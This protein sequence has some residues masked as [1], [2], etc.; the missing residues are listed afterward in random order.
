REGTVCALDPFAPQLPAW[1]GL[2]F[3]QTGSGKS[4]TLCQL[5]LQFYGQSP[6]PRIIW[7]DNGASSERLLEVL[8]GEFI[9]LTLESGI[10]MNMF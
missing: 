2:V 10:A 3:G 7:I 9:D 4:F 5:M 6:R 1:N 8:D